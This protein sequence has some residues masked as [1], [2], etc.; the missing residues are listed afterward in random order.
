MRPL[1][2][3]EHQGP[4]DSVHRH[5]RRKVGEAAE[6]HPT[7]SSAA[8]VVGFVATANQVLQLVHAIAQETPTTLAVV[9]GFLKTC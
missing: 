1:R 6:A 4:E 8:A 9:R 5:I 2:G 3:A 7:V